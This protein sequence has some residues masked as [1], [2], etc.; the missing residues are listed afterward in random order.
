LKTVLVA[1]PETTKLEAP[2]SMT[3]EE[4]DGI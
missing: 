4:C 1:D 2:S 3:S